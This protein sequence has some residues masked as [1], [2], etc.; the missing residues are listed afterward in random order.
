MPKI[1][2]LTTIL[3]FDYKHMSGALKLTSGWDTDYVF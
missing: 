1:R 2:V 3:S